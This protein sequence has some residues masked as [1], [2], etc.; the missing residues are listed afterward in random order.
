ME[1]MVHKH[2][3]SGT[4]VRNCDVG[5]Q[6]PAQHKNSNMGRHS[7][8]PCSSHIDHIFQWCFSFLIYSGIIIMS[9]SI[10]GMVNAFIAVIY[11]YVIVIL[12]CHK[13]LKDFRCT[14][15]SFIYRSC[16]VRFG[17]NHM[18]SFHCIY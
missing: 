9:F 12:K 3:A 5:Y 14:F 2:I 16:S 8:L 13:Y 7:L 1:H 18:L 10:S 6:L 4:N 15:K 11:Q 17:V